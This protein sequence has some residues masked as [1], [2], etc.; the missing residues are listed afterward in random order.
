MV[1]LAR[2]MAIFMS[3]HGARPGR[4]WRRRLWQSRW[5]RLGSRRAVIQ[6]ARL[7]GAAGFS[8]KYPRGCGM[9]H[10]IVLAIA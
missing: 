2:L 7:A 5:A 4:T 3:G 10:D 9:G 8:L 6:V 1:G